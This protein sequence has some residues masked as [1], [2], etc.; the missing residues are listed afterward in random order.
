MMKKRYHLFLLIIMLLAAYQAQAQ[1]K[2]DLN[3]PE[4]VEWFKD[5]GFG[6]F[7]HW[8]LDSQLGSV[9][10]HSMVG[11]SEDYLERYTKELPALFNP[12]QFD[13][14][15]WAALARLAGMQ[16]VV[17][18]AKHHSGFC[19]FET[20]TTDF[21]ILNTPFGRD[22]TREILDAFRKQGIA[23]G[24]YFSPDDFHFLYRNGLPID[25]DSPGS[26]PGGNEKLMDLT[27]KQLRELLTNYGKIDLIFIDGQYQKHEWV[28]TELARYCWELDPDLVVTRGGMETPEQRLPGQAL[29]GPWEACFTMGTQWQFKPTN[30]SYKSGRK[31]ISMLIETRA[32]GGNLLLNIG[33]EPNGTIP[34][35]QERLLREVALWNMVNREAVFNVAP[36]PVT[37]EEGGIWFTQKKGSDE[38]FAFLTEGNFAYG[39]PQTIHITSLRGTEETR[40]SVLGHRG[41]ILEYQPAVDP[42]PWCQPTEK[43]LLVG[44]MRAQRLYNDKTWSNPLVLKIE[45]VQFKDLD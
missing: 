25:R 27:K 30:E 13:P 29:D 37:R 15:E 44:F 6:M 10:S 43:G 4:R 33:P 21:N 39:E 32:K 7:I 38:V 24:L 5:L 18:T 8:S 23:V 12:R 42:S 11:A 22:A 17:F 40:V 9:I 2:L 41:E 31:I 45:N 1:L 16:Y 28:N 19:M 36:C 26:L 34:W 14:E 20:Q 3:K 35:E